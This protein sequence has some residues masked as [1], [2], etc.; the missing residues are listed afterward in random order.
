MKYLLF[1]LACLWLLPGL[2]A[3]NCA[4]YVNVSPQSNNGPWTLNAFAVQDTIAPP[5]HPQVIGYA[6]SNGATTNGIQVNTVGQY[7]V[8]ATFDNGCTAAKCAQVSIQP[9][10]GCWL[11]LSSQVIPGTTDRLVKAVAGPSTAGP[12]TYLWNNGQTTD[13]I[14]VS[15]PGLYCATV[16]SAQGNCSMDTCT[17]VWWKTCGLS[18]AQDAQKKHQRNGHWRCSLYLPLE[19]RRNHILPQQPG[20]R[21]ILPHYDGCNG[22]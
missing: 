18:I 13:Q 9:N 4:V 21:Y 20:Q 14:I 6:W 15:S 8:T 17:D 7:C 3:Q 10:S 2:Q 16:T 12:F 11:N 19:Q 1:F 5:P 22:L